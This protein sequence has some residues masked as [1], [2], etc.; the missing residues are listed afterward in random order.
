M[1][2]R[3]S[4][5]LV[6]EG[7]WRPLL[8]G[9]SHLPISK[10]QLYTQL[11]IVAARKFDMTVLQPQSKET[12]KNSMNHIRF[13]CSLLKPLRGTTSPKRLC[14]GTPTSMFQLFGVYL[15]SCSQEANASSEQ[16]KTTKKPK[17]PSQNGPKELHLQCTT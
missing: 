10:E 9:E 3:I 4:P 7:L 13:Q 15:R 6:L 8:L 12:R 11:P 2:D 17:V 14:K 5:I 16:N 1:E